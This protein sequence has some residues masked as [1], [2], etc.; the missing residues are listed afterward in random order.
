L[1]NKILDVSRYS[2]IHWKIKFWMCPECP[3]YIDKKNSGHVQI[4]QKL[5]ENKILDASRYSRIHWKIK[6]WTCPD[7]PEYIG[8]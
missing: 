8:K 7:I 4:F 5:L 1:E 6:F 3:K 2:R